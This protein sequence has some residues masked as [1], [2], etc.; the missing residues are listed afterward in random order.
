MGVIVVGGAT[1]GGKTALAI[2]LAKKY[3]GEV[4]SADA[5]LVYKRLNIGTAKPTEEEKEGIPH[6]LIDVAE[7]TEN[8]SVSDYERLA[9][10]VV[11]DILSRGKTPIICG[12]TGFYIKALLFKSQFGNVPKDEELR[13]KYEAIAEE[14][15]KEYLHELLRAVDAESA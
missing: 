15:G 8:F 13:K 11:E 7:P 6:H 12:G 3:N 5:L 2:R 9:L 1:A 10:P 14:R 4:V